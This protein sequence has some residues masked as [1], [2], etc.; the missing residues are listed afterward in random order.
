MSARAVSLPTQLAPARAVARGKR[1][2]RARASTAVRAEKMEVEQKCK[3][4]AVPFGYFAREQLDHKGP[5]TNVDRGDPH[6]FSRPMVKGMQGGRASCGSWA[7]SEGGW[8]SPNPRGTTEWFYVF[9]GSGAV[10]DPDGTPHPFG[11]GDVVVLPKGWLGRW[12]VHEFIHKVW[13]V[14]E[15]E[16]VGGASR[17]PVVMHAS[18]LV[19]DAPSSGRIGNVCYD[20]GCV[21][22][23]GWSAAPGTYVI[24]E[25]S[26]TEVFHVVDGEFFVTDGPPDG[27]SA[28][29]CVRGDTVVLPEG[30]NGRVDVVGQSAARAVCCEVSRDEARAHGGVAP[31]AARPTAEALAA[32]RPP[33]PPAGGFAPSVRA[34]TV[35]Y[36]PDQYDPD[37]NSG[38]TAGGFV[39][40]ARS[41]GDGGGG[42]PTRVT[43][44]DD[45][46]IYDPDQYDPENAGRSR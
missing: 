43:R 46:V 1:A 23:G 27:A 32:S 30:W 5:R 7:C 3:F 45:G 28:R 8:D 35:M 6:D 37:A 15:H 21:K 33:P 17:R 9:S 34:K 31:G 10:T 38:R 25:R 24:P 40:P 41:S 2:T 12:D 14:C 44:G 39:P 11:P 18:R 13:L 42:R 36:D 19:P 16:D 20:V 22:V 26:S 4:T 29:R